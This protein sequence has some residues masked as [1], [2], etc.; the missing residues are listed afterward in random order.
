MNPPDT[1]KRMLLPRSTTLP[2]ECQSLSNEIIGGPPPSSII[3]V[4]PKPRRPKNATC[5]I[6]EWEGQKP[7]FIHLFVELD[8]PL[9][10]VILK[11]DKDHHFRAT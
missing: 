6:E 8:L 3:A 10:D 4:P 1:I 11:M 9:R 5:T 7:T 2:T